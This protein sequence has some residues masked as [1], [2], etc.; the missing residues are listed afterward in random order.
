MRHALHFPDD[1]QRSKGI[2]LNPAMS[3]RLLQ[4]LEAT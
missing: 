3:G 4:G 1:P 2:G